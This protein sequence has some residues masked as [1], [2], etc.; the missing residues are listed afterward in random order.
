MRYVTDKSFNAYGRVLDL[1]VQ[2]F[3]EAIMQNPAVEAGQVVYET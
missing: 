2:D 3:I 1:D